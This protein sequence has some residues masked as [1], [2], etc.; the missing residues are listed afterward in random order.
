MIR[1]VY[2]AESANSSGDTPLSDASAHPWLTAYPSG[3]P[4][5]IDPD[6]YASLVDLLE[7]SCAQFATRPA[8]AS[9]GQVLTYAELDLLSKKFAGYLQSLGIARGDRIA[10]ML[11]NILQYPIALFGALRAGLTVV[12]TNPLYTAR[13]LKHQLTDSGATAIVVLENFAHVLEKVLDATP[14]RHVILT[15][16]GDM[17]QWPRRG[18]VN[19]AVRY[20]KRSVPRYHLP[21]AARW[22]EAMQRDAKQGFSPTAI[23]GSDLA[24]LQYTGGTTGVELTRFRGRVVI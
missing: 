15:S 4:A 16:V 11:P 8:F 24:L 19:L 21:H 14:V 17:L 23:S 5:Q 18:I 1:S 7:R 12:N 22:R 6:A 20:L 10:L 2:E 13:E 9:M 3:T